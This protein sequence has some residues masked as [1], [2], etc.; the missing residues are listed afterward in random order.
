VKLVRFVLRSASNGWGGI[1]PQLM[2]KALR[3][4]AALLAFLITTASVAAPVR[5]QECP[6]G[7]A[8]AEPL[9]LVD[10]LAWSPDDAFRIVVEIL[11]ELGYEFVR[12]DTAQRVVMTDVSFLTPAN[13]LLGDSVHPGIQVAAAIIPAGRRAQITWAA[14]ALCRLDQELPVGFEGWIETTFEVGASEDFAFRV[15]KRELATLG[16]AFYGRAKFTPPDR[17]YC[18]EEPFVSE[19]VVEGMTGTA[20]VGFVIDSTGAVEAGSTSVIEANHPAFARAA[21]A[22]VRRCRFRPGILEGRPVAVA[23]TQTVNFGIRRHR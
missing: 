1:T 20:T 11:R 3:Q 13:V 14:R 21:R 9:L 23:V 7:G 12:L 6:G 19:V 5:S 16:F 2:R 4:L 18:P 10:T 22:L 8:D 17:V 15:N